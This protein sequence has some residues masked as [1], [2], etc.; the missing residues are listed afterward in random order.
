MHL[1]RQKT[2]KKHTISERKRKIKLSTVFFFFFPVNSLGY[3]ESKLE[4]F[5]GKYD[6]EPRCNK[7]TLP[8]IRKIDIVRNAELK[9]YHL[10]YI[11]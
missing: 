7:N 11:L 6:S 10:H 2:S 5:E 9:N 4:S 8:S 3:M 1:F